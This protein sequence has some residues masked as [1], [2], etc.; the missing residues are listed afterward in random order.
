MFDWVL[1]TPLQIGL[2]RWVENLFVYDSCHVIHTYDRSKI[3]RKFKNVIMNY[4]YQSATE[5]CRNLVNLFF[6]I[7]PLRLAVPASR[8][9]FET[10]RCSDKF[11]KFCRKTHVLVFLFNRVV[12]STKVLK[13]PILKNI[14]KQLL[15]GSM[16]Y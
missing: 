12:N 5:F 14:C 1:N 4:F 7:Q 10:K 15:L 2:E 8:V 3:V 11:P 13:A 6:N 16:T 9:Q